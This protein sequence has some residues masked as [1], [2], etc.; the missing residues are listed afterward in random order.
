MLTTLRTMRCPSR[1]SASTAGL[2]VV[3]ERTQDA[4][5]CGQVHVDDRVPLLVAHLLDHAVPGVA[6]VVDQDV[7]AAE[8][9]DGSLHHPL[10]EI[11]CRDVAV[12]R[13]RTPAH[14]LDHRLDRLEARRLVEVVDHHRRAIA[15]Q[16]QRDLPPDAPARSGDDRHLAVELPHSACSLMSVGVVSSRYYR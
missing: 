14:R 15:R 10:A 8:G 5:R 11:L 16:P 12:A 4:E 7:A 13:H 3:E 2:Q 6:G 9:V 1:R